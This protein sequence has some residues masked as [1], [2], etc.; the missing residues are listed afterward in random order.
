LHTTINLF[1]TASPPPGSYFY[2]DQQNDDPFQHGAV[3]VLQKTQKQFK[4]ITDIDNPS[5]IILTLTCKSKVR[6][7]PASILVRL[8]FSQVSGGE[9]N[10]YIFSAMRL[11]SSNVRPM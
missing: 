7:R 4:I 2:Q 1:K 8:S 11:R 9:S 10:T 5:P 6:F 3:A